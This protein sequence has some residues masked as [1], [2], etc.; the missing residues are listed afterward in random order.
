MAKQVHGLLAR[1]ASYSPNSRLR[2][3][4]QPMQSPDSA[5]QRVLHSAICASTL[6]P[7]SATCRSCGPAA[8]GSGDRD[9]RGKSIDTKLGPDAA[10]TSASGLPRRSSLSVMSDPLRLTIVYEPGEDGVTRLTSSDI[11]ESRELVSSGRAATTVSGASTPNAPR[12]CGVI[13]RSITGWR[14]RSARTSRSTRRPAHDDGGN[15]N[16]VPNSANMTLS[17]DTSA[18]RI[19]G[20]A[21]RSTPGVAMVRRGS[22]VRVR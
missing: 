17:R 4:R 13:A 8:D 2:P 19:P 3:R 12:P 20:N 10:S 21:G 18:R 6:A 1:R 15:Q 9:T 7:P 11:Y 16:H 14:G 5:R 22:S